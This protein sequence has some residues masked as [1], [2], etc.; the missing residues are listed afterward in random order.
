MKKEDKLVHFVHVGFHKTGSTYLQ[1]EFFP[2]I[3]NLIIINNVN[4]EIDMWFYDNFI[5]VDS[6]SFKKK[7]FLK[8]FREITKNFNINGVLGISEENLSGEIYTGLEAR[9][10]MYRIHNVFGNVK[11][12]IVIRNQLDCILS[13]YSNYILHEGTRKLKDWLYSQDTNFGKIFNKLKYSYLIENYKKLF[14]EDNVKIILAEDLMGDEMYQFFENLN[15]QVPKI[16]KV[17]VNQG[18]SIFVNSLFTYINF[19][20]FGSIK[21]WNHIFSYLPRNKNDRNFL[22]SLIKKDLEQFVTDNTK[23][24]KMYKI[25]LPKEY[26]N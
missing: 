18:R 3:D 16:R 11:I 1:K 20:K 13:I 15:L 21:K 23:I 9:E 6:F 7:I 24:A 4:K 26:F 22:K 19:L 14:G 25:D 12:L 5:K 17:R 10:L 2:E 8:K